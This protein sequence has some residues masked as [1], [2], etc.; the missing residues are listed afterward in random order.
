MNPNKISLYAGISDAQLEVDDFHFG[1]GV[2]I[3]KTFAYV[4]AP[5]L[6]AFAP[7]KKGKPHPPPWKTVGGGFG[8]D[9]HVQLYVP[10]EF[11][12]PNWFDR[13]NSVWWIV[14][15]IRLIGA[16]Q[17]SVPVVA[18]APFTK[19]RDI[20]EETSIWPIEFTQH[21]YV[22]VTPISTSLKVEHLEWVKK[23]WLSGGHLLQNNQELN[24]AFQAFDAI[25]GVSDT[26][27][28]MLSLWGAL[29]SLF[30]PAR[31]ELRFRVSVNIAAFLEPFGKG[32]LLLQKK[33]AKLYDTR[34]AI[35]HGKPKKVTK[36]LMETYILM[37]R[38]LI[39]IFEDNHVPT[40]TELEQNL[41][42]KAT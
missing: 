37:R 1:H 21:R 13:L 4:M 12:P 10:Q 32:R 39:K 33:I 9:I 38:V 5:F 28:Y 29:E 16:P 26:S 34:C 8:C 27:L 7:A 35:A 15:L 31:T 23:H 40:K 42:G 14:A 17:V 25:V 11:C 36:P 18:S 20:K 30:S 19:M 24:I 22:P 6:I 3:S 41:L 2:V